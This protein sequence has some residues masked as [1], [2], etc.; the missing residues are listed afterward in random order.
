MHKKNEAECE[1]AKLNKISLKLQK[2]T[3]D[4]KRFLKENEWQ[5]EQCKKVWKKG[6]KVK[7]WK[8]KRWKWKVKKWTVK[9]K[10]TV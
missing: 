8:G 3:H 7:M 4:V 10:V 2:K 5:K 6:D 1:K 9:E